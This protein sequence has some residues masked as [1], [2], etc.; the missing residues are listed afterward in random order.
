MGP[1]WTAL[2]PGKS[3]ASFPALAS[4]SSPASPARIRSPQRDECV[5]RATGS[6]HVIGGGLQ[7]G[8]VP[9][10]AS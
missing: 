10:L 6:V 2:R 8:V 9:L 7:K 1:I 3:A 4:R 5:C